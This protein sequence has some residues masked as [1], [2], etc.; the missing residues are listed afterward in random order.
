[1]IENHF[2]NDSS[3]WVSISFIIFIGLTY[4]PLR[5]MIN[6]ALVEKIES[7]KVEINNSEKIKN[8][9]VSLLEET[10]KNMRQTQQ[11]C[12]SIEEDTKEK[13]RQIAENSKNNLQIVMKKKNQNFEK[14]ISQE[15]MLS[16][17]KIK[18]M[19]INTALTVAKNKI[20]KEI[21]EKD[22]QKLI[23]SSLQSIDFPLN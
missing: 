3:I 20:I 21:S 1:M 19:I 18:H 23:N 8:D 2:L 22:N 5:K 9:S 14:R 7:I 12:K 6:N 10:E 4:K 13:L 16:N 15:N 17:E 11:V